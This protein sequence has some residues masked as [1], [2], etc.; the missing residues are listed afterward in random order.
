[1]V[2]QLWLLCQYHLVLCI[3]GRHAL[4]GEMR[5]DVEQGPRVMSC[6]S[7]PS[8]AQSRVGYERGPVHGVLDWQVA[9]VQVA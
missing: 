5:W 7:Q 6:N 8:A 4:C 1:M 3:V 2:H 9:H